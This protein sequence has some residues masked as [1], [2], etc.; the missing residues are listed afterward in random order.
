MAQLLE[1]SKGKL[2]ENLPGY[3]CEA[4]HLMPKPL[5]MHEIHLPSN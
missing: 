5:A 1:Q 2:P 4:L 3:I